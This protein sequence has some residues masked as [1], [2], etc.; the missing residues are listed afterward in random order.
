MQFYGLNLLWFFVINRHTIPENT[1]REV[2]VYGGLVA[3][4]FHQ[5]Q[6]RNPLKYLIL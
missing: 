2:D 6:L 4:G 3:R 5:K 1:E